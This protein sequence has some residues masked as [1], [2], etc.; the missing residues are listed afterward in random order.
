[1]TR[2]PLF[3]LFAF[4]RHCLIGITASYVL[5]SAM[6]GGSN[7]AWGTFLVLAAVWCLPGWL[8]RV[9]LAQIRP[10]TV[11]MLEWAGVNLAL[12]AIL[13]EV[14]LRVVAACS[15]D[16]LLLSDTL[17]AHRLVPGRDYGHGLHGNRLGYPGREFQ[18]ERQLGVRRIAALG[19]S[20]AVGPAVPFEANF[21]CLLEKALGNTEIY[22]F[23]VS[24][25]GP[26]E[27]HAILR[28]HVWAVQPDLV[29]V[30]VFVGNDITESLA[31]PHHLDPRQ[32]ALY[33][34]FT[35]GGRLL[36]ESWRQADDSAAN[37][38]DRLAG[39]P[40]SAQAF[41]EVEARR[42]TVCLKTPTADLKKKWQRAF[43][44]LG[45]ILDDCR[46][47]Q[48]PVALV[49]IPDEFQV[50]PQV[51]T[52]ALQT[53]SLDPG[54]LDLT[55]PQQRLAAF[56]AA[57]GV[58]CLDLQPLFAKTTDTY[59]PR[60]THWN[61]R[62]NRLAADAISRFLLRVFPPRGAAGRNPP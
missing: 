39:P 41:R 43:G 30:C 13:A 20:F 59:A 14:S 10:R 62:G 56:C 50:H 45:R 8:L 54:A 25:T 55:L 29:L 12:T 58:A 32:H 60:D 6:V 16:S 52:E 48:T 44:H 40:L 49:L 7:A 31:T 42:L 34:F 4:L 26:R 21:L 53:A 23:G 22:N 57:K 11:G 3:Q 36:R 47:H 24:G 35:R 18:V 27:Y 51:L 38:T 1:V 61:I 19:D 2:F 37:R 33:L 15:G 28:Q 46:E 17:D 5:A 9:W